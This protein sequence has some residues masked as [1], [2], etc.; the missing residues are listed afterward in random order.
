MKFFSIN[1][2]SFTYSM[3]VDVCLAVL[4]S[5]CVMLLHFF[6]VYVLYAFLPPFFYFV[7]VVVYYCILVVPFLFRCSSSP[8]LF[9]FVL[10]MLC[11][12]TDSVHRGEASAGGVASPR[13]PTHAMVLFTVTV[14]VAHPFNFFLSLVFSFLLPVGCSVSSS[15]PPRRASRG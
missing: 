8:W 4:Y 3:C 1:D 14:T 5:Y 12:L 15:P 6:G 7:F 11:Y 13:V 10:V 2:F 9:G